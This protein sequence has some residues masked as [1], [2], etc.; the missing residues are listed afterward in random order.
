MPLLPWLAGLAA[1]VPLEDTG[2]PLDDSGDTGILGLPTDTET[3]VDTGAPVVWSEGDG[4][5]ELSG[6]AGGHSWK[7][8]ATAPGVAWALPL[9]LL[10][11]R[12]RR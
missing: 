3:P 1:A 2:L 9:L 6:E 7:G 5:A 12:A 11:R 4:A 10:V 8:C